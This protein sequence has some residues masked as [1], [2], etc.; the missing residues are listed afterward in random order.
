MIVSNNKDQTTDFSVERMDKISIR[1]A[2]NS[3]TMRALSKPPEGRVSL[4]RIMIFLSKVLR[5]KIK[6][7]IR[8]IS[9]NKI[10][11]NTSKIYK[12][13]K[14]N[15]KYQA[16]AGPARPG[17]SPAQARGRARAG[18]AP[19]GPAPWLGLGRPGP[20]WLPPSILHLSRISCISCIFWIYI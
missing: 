14:I 1:K 6:K 18:P 12:I 11:P 20:V 9:T 7:Y 10:C 19:R 5:K 2:R 15:S 17:P 16:A 4:W 3:L 8:N 13:Y